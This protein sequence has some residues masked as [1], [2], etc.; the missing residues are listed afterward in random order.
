MSCPIV[1]GILESVIRL[2]SETPKSV[3]LRNLHLQSNKDETPVCE[4]CCMICNVQ[5]DNLRAQY[6]HTSHFSVAGAKPV[7]LSS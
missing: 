7:E 5:C 6:I 1:V 2:M 3:V 4:I